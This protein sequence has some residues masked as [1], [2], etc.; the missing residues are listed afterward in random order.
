[1]D[2][3]KQKQVTEWFE[4]G[5]HD[6]ET[7]KLL[8]KEQGYTDTITHHIHQAVEKYL[9]GFLVYKNIIPKKTHDLVQLVGGLIKDE[10]SLE[11]FTDFCDKATKYYIEDRYPPGPPVVYSYDEIKISLDLACKLIERI[12]SKVRLNPA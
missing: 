1:M 4:R 12:K 11:E 8:Y 3:M 2:E 9:K 5:K 6:I 10:P 7:A